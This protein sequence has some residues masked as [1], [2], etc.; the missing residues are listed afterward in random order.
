MNNSVSA[1][2]RFEYSEFFTSGVDGREWT[3]TYI[4][5]KT[6]RGH[7]VRREAKQKQHIQLLIKAG[8]VPT[9]DAVTVAVQS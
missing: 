9:Y 7:V 1:L 2:S 5:L 6:P 4:N 3:H 8:Y